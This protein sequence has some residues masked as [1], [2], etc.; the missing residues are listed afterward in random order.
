MINVKE[1][2]E[3]YVRGFVRAC[4]DAG[5]TQEQTDLAASRQSAKVAV[6]LSD[7][8]APVLATGALGTVLMPYFVGHMAGEAAA[9]IKDTADQTELNRQSSAALAREL[10][11]RAAKLRERNATVDGFPGAVPP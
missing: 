8:G 4:R 11:R 5:M 6:D 9:N 3:Q 1:A 2:A 10:R 7:L